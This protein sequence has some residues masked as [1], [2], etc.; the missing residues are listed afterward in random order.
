MGSHRVYTV[1]IFAGIAA[2]VSLTGPA[3]IP[4]KNTEGPRSGALEA[5]QYF[6]RSR[7]YPLRDAP[8]GAFGA[9]YFRH[10]APMSRFSAQSAP[11]RWTSLGP[12][13]VGGRTL[14]IAVNP[15]NPNTIWAGSASG[16]L[17]RSESRGIGASAWERIETGHPVLGVSSIAIAPHDTAIMYIGTGEVYGYQRALGGLVDRLTRGSFGIGILKSTDGGRTWTPSLDWSYDSRGG[18]WEV[19]INPIDPSIVW[20][21][22][23]EGTYR[24]SDAG[25]TWTRVHDVPMAMSLVLHPSD[26]SRVYVGC[27]NFGSAGGGV[28]RST[29]AGG[30]WTLLA[31]GFPTV[32]SG[33]ISLELPRNAPATVYACV[34]TVTAPVTG[35]AFCISRDGGDTWTI[36]GASDIASYQGWYSHAVL[37]HPTDTT[38]I[39]CVGIDAWRSKNAGASFTKI[40]DWRAS[41]DGIVEPGEAE[42]DPNFVHADIHALTT[43]PL[44]PDALYLATDGGIFH[45]DTFGDSFE[46]RNGGYQS[47]QFYNGAP[48]HMRDSVLIIGGLQD[49]GT[50]IHRGS[51]A[52][53]RVLGGDGAMSLLHPASTARLYAST[54]YGA[55]YRST[56]NGASW[57][58]IRDADITAAFVAPFALAV[59][60]PDILYSGERL[61]YK[62]TDA[63]DT[64]KAVNGGA[65]LD[66]DPLLAIAVSRFSPDTV[67]ATTAPGTKRAR[68][69]VS[70]NGGT[71]WRDITGTLPDRFLVD[72][73]MHPTDARTAYITASGFGSGH[74]WKTSDAGA[75]WSDAGAG[76]PDLPTSA[77]AIDPDVPNTVYAGNDYG[78]YVS[79][80]GGAQWMAWSDG[81]PS[82]VIAMDLSVSPANRALRVAT[83]GNGVYERALLEPAISGAD[84]PAPPLAFALE[85][86]YPHPA[87]REVH[88]R[89]RSAAGETVRLIVCTASGQRHV[90]KTMSATSPETV[91]SLPVTDMPP[92]AY[93]LIA[94]MRGRRVARPFIIAR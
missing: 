80:D 86:P 70:F 38:R 20:A 14:A 40:S 94:E 42:G 10:N 5:L 67:Y 53:E 41:F 49:N 63:G 36:R 22:T 15:L 9:A 13:N 21:A 89:L 34:G 72:I 24:S 12:N 91:L 7:T 83:H 26:P 29:D 30:H 66:G 39:L 59:S 74:V 68:A 44:H 6:A 46:A 90:E 78:V 69:F 37:P 79:R 71:S 43:D 60:H 48:S 55:R 56:D 4:R 19:R 65:A 11:S 84:F 8:A 51:R 17:W 61:V 31:N 2:A 85:A 92:G 82:A 57:S 33:K 16:G 18:V 77:V 81:L 54:Q 35:T 28:Y 47:S 76:L 52:W 62:S 64:W 23:T 3:H 88:A 32:F 27:G 87:A 75:S 73:A 25:G 93:F 1:L 45:T 58:H 50:V